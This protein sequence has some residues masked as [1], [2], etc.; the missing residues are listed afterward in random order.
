MEYHRK[1]YEGDVAAGL[2]EKLQRN[3]TVALVLEA[4]AQG[5]EERE[6]YEDNNR[7]GITVS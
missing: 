4:E 7:Q 5:E 3:N 6:I 1:G 2:V